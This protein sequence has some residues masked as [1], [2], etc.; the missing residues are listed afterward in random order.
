M[1]QMIGVST[2]RMIAIPAPEEPTTSSRPYAPPETV[3]NM[4]K[5]R[6]PSVSER[7]TT[8][9]S[10]PGTGPTSAVVTATRPPLLGH[11]RGWAGRPVRITES[12]HR[13]AY[14]SKA[15][16]EQAATHD[17]RAGTGARTVSGLH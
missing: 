6:A 3:K 17:R 16:N 11:T 1:L 4:M 5:I 12:F 7:L 13:R 14:A 10:G 15:A 8:L 9:T 2:I